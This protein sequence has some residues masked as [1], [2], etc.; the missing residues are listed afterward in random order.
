MRV[1]RGL[2]ALGAAVFASAALASHPRAILP[3]PFSSV[4]A[5]G[6]PPGWRH[7]T[8]AFW[9]RSTDYAAVSDDGATVIKASARAAASSLV[10]NLDVD[11]QQLPGI[12]WR[13]KVAAAPQGAD[14]RLKDAEDAPV[15][16]MLEFGGASDTRDENSMSGFLGLLSDANSTHRILMYI[17]SDQVRAESVIA[18]PR[19]DHIRMLVVGPTS[20]G[21]GRWF[22]HARNYRADFMHVFGQPPARLTAVGIMTDADNTGSFAQAYYGDIRLL[23]IDGLGDHEMR[24]TPGEREARDT[25]EVR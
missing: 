20:T 10:F 14:N 5:P 21:L 25:S 23:A 6:T 4:S 19:T 24:A 3:T 16:L 7:T 2:L 22:S 8:I 12:S 9:K 17:T 18:N 15:R 11:P 1:R 13:W